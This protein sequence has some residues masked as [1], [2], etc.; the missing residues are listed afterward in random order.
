[1]KLFCPSFAHNEMMPSRFT[2]DGQDISPSLEW[3][4]VPPETQSFALIV[5]DPD[6]PSGTWVH[7]VIFNI[8]VGVS[9]LEEKI[10]K[11]GNLSGGVK[12]G[13]NSWR[14][15]GYGGPCPPSGTHRY[16]FKFIA[17]DIVLDLEAGIT[18]E[19]LLAAMRGHVLAS[20]EMIGLYQRSS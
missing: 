10:K 1:M 4:D 12:Q 2:C 17:L 6:A 5:D 18:K 20:H 3:E 14:Q 9:H 16:F 8:P 7:W 13:R 15:I 11:E 19:E